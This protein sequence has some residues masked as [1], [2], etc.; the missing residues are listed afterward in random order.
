MSIVPFLFWT[1]A[2]GLLYL[3]LFT[4]WKRWKSSRNE[5]WL[6][7]SALLM[8]IAGGATLLWGVCASMLLRPW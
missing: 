1:A 4:A 3:G 8:L 7:M 5:V 6:A 2:L